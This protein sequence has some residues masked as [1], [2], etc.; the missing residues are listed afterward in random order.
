MNVT[1]HQEK[2]E[3]QQTKTG[4]RKEKVKTGDRFKRSCV[5]PFCG[6]SGGS[7][8]KKLRGVPGVAETLGKSNSHF[9]PTQTGSGTAPP[10]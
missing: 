5:L 2:E 7:I 3:N 10:H 1:A 4:K 6:R 9:D 8:A